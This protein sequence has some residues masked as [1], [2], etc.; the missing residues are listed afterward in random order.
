MKIGDIYKSKDGTQEIEIIGADL[1]N[2][3]YQFVHRDTMGVMSQWDDPENIQML[4]DLLDFLPQGS[5]VK[6][7]KPHCWHNKKEKKWLLTTWYWYCP[8]CGKEW[9]HE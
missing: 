1:A 3:K 9:E 8:D 6:D 2:G 4:L 5:L 7:I